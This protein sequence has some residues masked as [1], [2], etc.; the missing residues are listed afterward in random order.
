MHLSDYG[1]DVEGVVFRIKDEK[2]RAAAIELFGEAAAGFT[3]A[4]WRDMHADLTLSS[5]VGPT[6]L[7]AE[8]DLEPIVPEGWHSYPENKPSKKGFYSVLFVFACRVVC[9]RVYFTGKRFDSIE[10][11]FAWKELEK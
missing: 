8:V 3:R 1:R 2:K 4:D 6:T 7:A 5:R 11:I 9:G 10:R